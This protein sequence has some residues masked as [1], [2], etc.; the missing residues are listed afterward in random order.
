MIAKAE[1]RL[2]LAPSPA[3]LKLADL[4]REERDLLAVYQNGSDDRYVQALFEL[5]QEADRQPEMGARVSETVVASIE[6]DS[7][8]LKVPAMGALRTLWALVRQSKDKAQEVS[9]LRQKIAALETPDASLDKA[10]T[11]SRAKFFW[12]QEQIRRDWAKTR[13]Q[14]HISAAYRSR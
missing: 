13:R 12:L 8:R 2:R 9:R 4:L 7:E 11:V 6:N 3:S 1:A 5:W 14:L 10:L